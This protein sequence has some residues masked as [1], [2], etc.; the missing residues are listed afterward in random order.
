MRSLFEISTQVREYLQLYR[1]LAFISSYEDFISYEVKLNRIP[2][3]IR[4][5]K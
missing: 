1:L 4:A 2:L 3:P 5:I